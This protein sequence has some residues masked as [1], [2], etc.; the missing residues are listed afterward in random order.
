MHFDHNHYPERRIQSADPMILSVRCSFF[1]AFFRYAFGSV[2]L[3]ASDG[4][5]PLKNY[6]NYGNRVAN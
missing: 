6:L 2:M 3:H 1:L 4:I 5:F